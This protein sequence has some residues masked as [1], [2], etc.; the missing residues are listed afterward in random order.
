MGIKVSAVCPGFVDNRREYQTQGMEP[1][2]VAEAV[3]YV[4]ASGP[5]VCPTRIHL[6]EQRDPHWGE[7]DEAEQAGS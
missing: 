3:Y 6:K 2:D 5:R 1:E 7:P 4:A